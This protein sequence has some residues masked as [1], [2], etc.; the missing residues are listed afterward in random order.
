MYNTKIEPYTIGTPRYATL[1]DVHTNLSEVAEQLDKMSLA[2][3]VNYESA[4][5]DIDKDIA[6]ITSQ[7]DKIKNPLKEET[8]SNLEPFTEGATSLLSNKNI[9]QLEKQLKKQ[10]RK[11]KKQE[12]EIEKLIEKEPFSTIENILSPSQLKG[13]EYSNDNNNNNKSTTYL[14]QMD[15]PEITLTAVS[16]LSPNEKIVKPV[17]TDLEQ[18]EEKPRIIERSPV[19]QITLFLFSIVGLFILHRALYTKRG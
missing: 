14:K 4:I 8:F 7:I 3:G 13:S 6:Y 15:T 5:S 1:E 12:Q 9:T 17:N 10:N 18:K 2:E 11:I 16:T 19:N